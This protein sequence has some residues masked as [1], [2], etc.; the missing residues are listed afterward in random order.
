MFIRGQRLMC[1][2]RLFPV[3]VLFP[4]LFFMFMTTFFFHPFYVFFIYRIHA[5]DQA[6]QSD[7]LCID[8][9][10][11]ILHPFIVLTAHINKQITILDLQNVL[12]CRL[13]GVCLF[14]RL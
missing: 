7:M 13:I 8:G 3:L 9:V 6:K 4:F 10:Q 14:S 11:N 12:R 2:V 5:V 1:F